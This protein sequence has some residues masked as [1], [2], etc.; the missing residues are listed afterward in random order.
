MTDLAIGD[1]APDFT[2]PRNG[3]G[4]INLASLQGKAVVLYFYPKD[5]TSGCTVQALDF[6][7]MGADFE[8]AN[9]VVIGISPDSVKSHDKFAA[10]HALTVM[11]ASDEEKTVLETY[12]VWKEKSMYGKKYMGVERTT[13]LIA[14]DGKIAKVWNKVKPAGHAQIVL[15]AIRAL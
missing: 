2:L 11:L 6:S 5:D 3:G 12:G 14:P 15:E 10:K 7:A 9:S 13:Y 1:K 4:E 8:A